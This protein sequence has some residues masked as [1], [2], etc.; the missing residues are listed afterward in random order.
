MREF[1]I[2]DFV[3]GIDGDIIGCEGIITETRLHNLAGRQLLITLTKLGTKPWHGKEEWILGE[4]TPW[5]NWKGCIELISS[6]TKV[7][8]KVITD[9]DSIRFIG[10]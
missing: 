7:G 3:R 9:S 5:C 1:K 6:D 10:G 8:S 4:P 2:G